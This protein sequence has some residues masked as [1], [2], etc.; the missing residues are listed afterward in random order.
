MTK[1]CP[2]MSYR[3]KY[4]NEVF[5]Q[6]EECALWDEARGCCCFMTQALAAFPHVSHSTSNKDSGK[7]YIINPSSYCKTDAV[8][9]KTIQIE[10]VPFG[11]PYN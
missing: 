10:S 6:E 5:C 2:F 1:T 7:P 11:A 4:Y 9:D 8:S 3:D